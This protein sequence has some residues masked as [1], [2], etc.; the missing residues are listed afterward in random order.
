LALVAL[1]PGPIHAAGFGLFEQGTRAMGMSGAFTA[2]ADD[3]SLLFHNAGGLAFVNSLDWSLGIT[4]V[5]GTEGTFQGAAPFP[6]PSAR[7]EQVPLT[8]TIYHGYV[9]G[10]I[11]PTWKWGLGLYT[12]FGLETEWENPRTFSGRFFSTKAALRAIDVNPTLG[13]QV[14]P[15]FGI[16]LGAVVR[17][18]DLILKRHVLV[19]VS[20]TTSVEAGGLKLESDLDTGFGWN[21]GVL[22]K[23]TPSFSWGFSYRSKI[24]VDYGGEARLVQIPTGSPTIDA[25]LRA[26]LPYN[27]DLPVETSIEFPDMA[28]LGLAFSL[29][30]NVLIE[31]DVN[32]TGWSSFDETVIRFTGSPSQRL[33][34]ATVRSEW[35]DVYNY[36]AGLRWTASP[37]SQWRFGIYYDETPQPEESVGPLLPDANRQ[38]LSLGYGYTGAWKL[39]FAVL[40]VDFDERTRNRSFSGEPPF[41]GTYQNE[42]WLFGLTVGR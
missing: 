24:E 33:P 34:D 23:P 21:F 14:T 7:G 32:W 17:S 40:Y 1:S 8:E 22:H 39:D 31:T 42:A 28:S 12:P 29:S 35:D 3:P 18:S 9:V 26:I 19:P 4:R 38:G 25:A 27:Q 41:F 6:G 2:Q 13:W 15:T 16:G 11:N 30:P 20:P 10:A 37:S 36:R 5:E